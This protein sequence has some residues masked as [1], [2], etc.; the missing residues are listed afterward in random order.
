KYTGGGGNQEYILRLNTSGNMEI[1]W[2]STG[3]S[4]RTSVAGPF[5]TGQWY[6][7]AAW[8]DDA[9][10]TL[11]VRV[12]DGLP[13]IV[14]TGTLGGGDGAAD[15]VLGGRDGSAVELDGLLDEWSAWSRHL[16]VG[17]LDW[18]RNSGA[19]R[20]YADLAPPSGSPLPAILTALAAAGRA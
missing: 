17:E 18:L 5:S 8:Y 3:G 4:D 15:F 6:F 20:T 14:G 13:A 12:D 19:G 11:G 16:S 2:Y 7:V 1:I 10:G 9:L